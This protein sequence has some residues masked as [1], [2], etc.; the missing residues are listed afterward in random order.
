MWFWQQVGTPKNPNKILEA[1][2]PSLALFQK[3][4]TVEPGVLIFCF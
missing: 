1:H 2:R 3:I 4:S